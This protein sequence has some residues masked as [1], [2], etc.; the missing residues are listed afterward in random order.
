M[1]KNTSL[2]QRKINHKSFKNTSLL[3]LGL[4]LIHKT[5]LYYGVTGRSDVFSPKLE[6]TCGMG[7][8]PG[9]SWQVM[10]GEG[11]GGSRREVTE[12][13]EGKL[14]KA[15]KGKLADRSHGTRVHTKNRTADYTFNV[16]VIITE[17]DTLHSSYCAL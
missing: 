11:G 14:V 1:Q 6:V 3:I 5:S 17:F 16:W 15:D 7:P 9:E 2:P 8:R 13:A 10:P 4:L 12:P